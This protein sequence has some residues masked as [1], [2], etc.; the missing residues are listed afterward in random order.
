[1][2]MVGNDR[3]APRV[4]YDFEDLHSAEVGWHV[5]VSCHMREDDVVKTGGELMEQRQQPA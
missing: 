2:G 1:M 3:G 5:E 4:R